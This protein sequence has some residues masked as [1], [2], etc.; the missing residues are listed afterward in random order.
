MSYILSII[1]LACAVWVIYDAISRNKKLNRAAKLIW[2]ICAVLFP[3]IPA[4]VYY[5]FARER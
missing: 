3:I 1:A 2:V 4:I 5:F